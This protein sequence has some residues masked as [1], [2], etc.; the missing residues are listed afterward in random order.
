MGAV[1]YEKLARFYDALVAYD[2]DVAFFVD[3]SKQAGGP[4]LELMAGTGRVSLP[5]AREG[6]ELTCVDSSP[7]MLDELRRKLATEEL[8]VEVVLQDA[9]RLDLD[10]CFALAFLAFNSFEELTADEDRDSFLRRVHEHL[11]PGGRFVCTLHDPEVRLRDV[12]PGRDRRWRFRDPDDGREL[13]LGLSTTFEETA[14][15]VRGRQTLEDPA[16]G[17]V[18]EDLP[19]CFRLTT[20]EE[21]RALARRAGFGVEAL[22][23][24]YEHGRYTAGRSAGMVWILGQL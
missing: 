14:S 13:E 16:T 18:I 12:G 9:T 11:L 8:P 7:A 24:D 6:V 19:L 22:Y 1:A 17:K 10:P 15:L 21:F 5:I 2:D 3:L 23:G 4:V 20:C